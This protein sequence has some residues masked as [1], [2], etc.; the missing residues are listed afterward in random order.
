MHIRALTELPTIGRR[1]QGVSSGLSGPRVIITVNLRIVY[2][3]RR[4]CK[5]HSRMAKEAAG[6]EQ[7]FTLTEG[8]GNPTN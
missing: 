1:L 6:T 7:G 8:H 4:S 2:G 3:Y 5:P